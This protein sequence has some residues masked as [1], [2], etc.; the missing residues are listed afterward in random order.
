LFENIAPEPQ[1]SRMTKLNLAALAA[2]FKK[3]AGE[4]TGTRVAAGF[5]G[6]VDEIISVV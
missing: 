2:E 1:R 4:L 6:F 5:D 3:R